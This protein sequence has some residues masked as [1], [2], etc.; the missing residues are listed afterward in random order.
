MGPWA[1]TVTHKKQDVPHKDADIVLLSG[2][3]VYTVKILWRREERYKGS[4]DWELACRVKHTCEYWFHALCPGITAT[5][6]A[7]LSRAGW[8]CPHNFMISKD[9]YKKGQ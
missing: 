7:T 8:K 2:S 3:G 1:V 5:I 9:K 6:K 4:M